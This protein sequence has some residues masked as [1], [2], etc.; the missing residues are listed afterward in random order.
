MERYIDGTMA[1]ITGTYGYTERA[2]ADLASG[3]QW[4]IC[5]MRVS[6]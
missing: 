6:V 2:G 1:R 5:D 3:S 4:D